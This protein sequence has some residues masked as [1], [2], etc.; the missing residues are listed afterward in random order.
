MLMDSPLEGIPS[1]SPVV[2]NHRTEV[3]GHPR[4]CKM[5]VVM[6]VFPQTL[7]SLEWL[8]FLSGS[9]RYSSRLLHKFHL[10]HNGE[11]YLPVIF[12]CDAFVVDHIDNGTD[13]AE[14]EGK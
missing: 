9:G 11:S 6:K 7:S 3:S 2:R 14:S 5:R 10:I 1:S 4:A 12:E 13:K 8:I